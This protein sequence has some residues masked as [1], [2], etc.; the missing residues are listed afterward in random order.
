MKWAFLQSQGKLQCWHD[1]GKFDEIFCKKLGKLS[2]SLVLDLTGDFNL[3]DVCWK[4]ETAQRKQSRRFLA[5]LVSEAAREGNNEMTEIVGETRR[6]S[7]TASLD[8]QGTGAWL[9]ASLERQY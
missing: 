4:Y 6:I 3:S 7:R 2:Q 9:R 5:Q 8:F 1:P